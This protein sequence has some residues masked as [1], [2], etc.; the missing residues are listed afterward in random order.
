MFSNILLSKSNLID[1]IKTLKEIGKGREICVMI[2]A[3]AYGHGAKEI[4]SILN[5]TEMQ[6]RLDDGN[7]IICS[8]GPGDFTDQGHFI[9]IR[10]YSGSGFYV[11]DPFSRTN[12]KKVWKYETLSGQVQQIWVY[13]K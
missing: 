4:V 2:K 7:L 1:N 6:A 11:N 10:G 13:A 9:V 3:E 12:S 5:E 8:M